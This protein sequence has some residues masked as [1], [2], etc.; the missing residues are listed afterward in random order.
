MVTSFGAK[1]AKLVF[2]IETSRRNRRVRQPVERDV[3]ED[4]VS[5][6][7]LGLPVKDACDELVA[8]RVVVEHP[9]GQADG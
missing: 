5:R 4:I 7:A 8:A 1:K 9:G 6:Q 3:V 2:P